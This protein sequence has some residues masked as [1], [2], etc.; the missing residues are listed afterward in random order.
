MGHAAVLDVDPLHPGRDDLAQL[1]QHEVGI[2]A[3]F[4]ERMGSHPDEERLIGLAAGVDAEV[5]AGGGRQQATQSVERLGP[6]RLAPDEVGV[7][8][9]PG[10][11]GREPGLQQR[12]QIGIGVEEPVHVAHVAGAERGLQ[13]L[14]GPEVPVATV[15]Q[16]A[17][18]GHVAGRLLHV[19]HEPA[20]L[21]D[22]GQQV[23]G[24]LAGQVHAAELGNGVVAV[25]EEHP[26][27]ELLGPGQAHGGVHAVVPADVEVADELVEEQAPKALGGAGVAS[28]QGSLDDL[29]QVDQGEHGTVQVGEVAPEDLGFLG[30]PLFD[31]VEPGVAVPHGDGAA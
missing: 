16:A 6:H 27:V 9:R 7:L 30:G 25:L 11:L 10:V 14:R 26:V 5:G 12:E 15:R 13:D 3:G 1:G 21:E 24:L 29:G 23:G 8:G 28:E 19:G 17:V 2:H 22:L 20:P 31:G 18:V 4:G